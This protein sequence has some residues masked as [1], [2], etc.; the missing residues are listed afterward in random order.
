MTH[1]FV[2]Q[3]TKAGQSFGNKANPWQ[4]LHHHILARLLRALGL[5][6]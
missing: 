5:S 1:T 6:K 2:S 4:T 3:V